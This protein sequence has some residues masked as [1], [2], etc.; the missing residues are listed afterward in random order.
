VNICRDEGATS[1]EYGLIAGLIAGVVAASVTVVG[2][3]VHGL[4]QSFL[5]QAS[6]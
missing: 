5:D 6:F 2:T 1:V 3:A 4:F